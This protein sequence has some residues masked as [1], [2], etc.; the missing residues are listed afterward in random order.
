[1]AGS[2]LPFFL[3]TFNAAW[4][5]DRFN[6]NSLSRATHTVGHIKLILLVNDHFSSHHGEFPRHCN[7][8][9]PTGISIDAQIRIFDHVTD[10]YIRYFCLLIAITRIE[11]FSHRALAKPAHVQEPIRHH[12]FHLT[13]GAN[14]TRLYRLKD[15]DASSELEFEPLGYATEAITSYQLFTSLKNNGVIPPSTRFQ[16]S[17]PT[18]IAVIMAFV[19]PE[20]RSL[21]ELAY[22]KAMRNEQNTILENIPAHE[23]AIQWD[24][25]QELVAYEGNFSF[26]Y[27]DI[28]TGTCKRVASLV[29]NIPDAVAIGIHLCYGD[30]GHKHIIEPE[31]LGNCVK[32]ANAIQTQSARHIN[33]FHMPVLRERKDEAYFSP[34]KTL[35]INDAE[36]VLGLVHYTDGVDGTLDRIKAANK[37]VTE[38]SIASEC[39]FGRREPATILDLLSIH[40]EVFNRLTK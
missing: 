4:K 35:Q 30:P 19:I 6:I 5:F 18:P 17:L 38:Y 36:L 13:I 14:P 7:R 22:T 9:D 25:A 8:I 24:I 40:A 12:D 26:P 1:M 39:G 32:F 34:L 28:L 15:P 20:H 16:V 33:Y 27:D 11:F 21:V 31:D 29:E 10:P 2:P 3:D 23:L 37:V